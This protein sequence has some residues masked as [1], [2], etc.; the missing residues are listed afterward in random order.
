MLVEVLKDVESNARVCYA[1]IGLKTRVVEDIPRRELMKF[2]VYSS[3]FS[4]TKN[5]ELQFSN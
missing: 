3:C 5:A 2:V 1:A 4:K